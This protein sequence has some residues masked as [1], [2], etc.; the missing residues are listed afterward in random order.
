MEA[1]EKGVDLDGHRE[2]LTNELFDVERLVIEECTFKLL[3][4]ESY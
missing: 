2:T 3:G 4:P 1:F